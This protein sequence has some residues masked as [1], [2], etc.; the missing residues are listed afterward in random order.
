MNNDDDDDE[1]SGGGGR[2]LMTLPNELL[3]M[4]L[5][6]TDWKTRPDAVRTCVQ[7][8]NMKSRAYKNNVKSNRGQS[9]AL[10][11]CP[12][13]LKL[14][15]VPLTLPRSLITKKKHRCRRSKSSRVVVRA[16]YRGTLYCSR[17]CA[18][19][20]HMLEA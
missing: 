7:L 18:I 14:M 13:C 20:Q 3:L 1:E 12:R 17:A 15:T 4:I 19:E 10:K 9:V 16:H 8:H 6:C 11:N 5:E 2:T